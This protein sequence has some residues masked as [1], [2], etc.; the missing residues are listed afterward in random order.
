HPPRARPP[1]AALPAPPPPGAPP[2]PRRPP[3]SRRVPWQLPWGGP[4][5][6]PPPAPPATNI[7][8]P[9]TARP[10]DPLSAVDAT[11]IVPFGLDMAL[12]HCPIPNESRQPTCA[13][14]A[15]DL[16]AARFVALPT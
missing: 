13:R 1:P 10:I 8:P 12:R 9:T 11:M 6:G 16:R 2:P 4:T 3:T 15:C 14:A 7:S 5:L